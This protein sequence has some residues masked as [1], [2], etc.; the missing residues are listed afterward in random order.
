MPPDAALAAKAFGGL[1]RTEVD[2]VRLVVGAQG[3]R[4]TWRSRR[5]RWW[6]PLH[7]LCPWFRFRSFASGQRKPTTCLV[8]RRCQLGCQCGRDQ[9]DTQPNERPH[10]TCVAAVVGAAAAL[11]AVDE[12]VLLSG[13]ARHGRAHVRMAVVLVFVIPRLAH[14]TLA[15]LPD[16]LRHPMNCAVCTTPLVA[17]AVLA[18]ARWST[19]GSGTRRTSTRLFKYQAL[20]RVASLAASMGGEV[21]AC[22]RREDQAAA[23]FR[24]I[25]R[26][27][28]RMRIV[29]GAAC[30]AGT[31]IHTFAHDT[32]AAAL[33]PTLGAGVGVMLISTGRMSQ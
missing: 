32:D 10:C 5:P 15:T 7:R 23:G 9:H 22:V 17:S 13:A 4:P 30:L 2:R 20:A 33:L 14:L 11:S 31:S 25:S 6:R 12:H 3:W 16:R 8:K 24:M 26:F 28:S 19:T 1:G 21:D 18:R 27:E 29:I